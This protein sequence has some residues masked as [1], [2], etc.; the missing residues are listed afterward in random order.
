MTQSISSLADRLLELAAQGDENTLFEEAAARLNA[1][2]ELLRQSL[3]H[4]QQA[5]QSA[6]ILSDQGPRHALPEDD[7]AS[8]I[9]AELRK[10]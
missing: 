9:R 4:V 5:A 1:R 7:L 8:K 10:Q 6:H 2:S 3:R